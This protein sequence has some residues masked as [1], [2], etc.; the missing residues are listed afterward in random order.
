MSTVLAVVVGICFLWSLIL[1]LVALFTR[2]RHQEAGFGFT[3]VG[4][5]LYLV[6]FCDRLP[7]RS[8]GPRRVLEVLPGVE[9][10]DVLFRSSL[11]VLIVIA[12]VYLYRVQ[13][14]YELYFHDD[15]QDID[16]DGVPDEVD[17]PFIRIV[18]YVTLVAVAM[19]VLQPVYH[20]GAV[21]TA[22]L[23]L[24]LLFGF[25]IKQLSV[26][27]ELL[28]DGFRLVI[29]ASATAWYWYRDALGVS[30]SYVA[31]IG[32]LGEGGAPRREAAIK[33]Q[34]ASKRKLAELR[35]NAVIRR[36]EILNDAVGAIE[37]V[38]HPKQKES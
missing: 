17:D 16:G 7:G 10:A 32:A 12:V 24:I 20:L 33:R 28:V 34:E 14:F 30:I 25:F 22:F 36:R 1:I 23:T 29:S 9:R 15:E 38:R 27:V 11:A 4:A 13:S 21:A 26:V 31:R 6:A 37:K 35:A 18:S 8:I 3:L 19:A 2:D 5:G